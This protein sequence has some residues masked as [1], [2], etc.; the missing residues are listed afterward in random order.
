MKHWTVRTHFIPHKAA[1]QRGS[2]DVSLLDDVRPSNKRSLDVPESMDKV[3]PVEVRTSIPVFMKEVETTWFNSSEDDVD[4][5]TPEAT[6]LAFN[7]R[8]CKQ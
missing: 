2:E 7:I 4:K 1:W 6:G 5:R 3:E 8:R